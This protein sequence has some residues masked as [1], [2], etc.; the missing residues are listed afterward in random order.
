MRYVRKEQIFRRASNFARLILWES[1]MA[2]KAFSP[3][4]ANIKTK[5][6][7]YI[8]VFDTKTMGIRTIVR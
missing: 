3:M 5:M 1:Q 4:S 2:S 6:R 8:L 7:R